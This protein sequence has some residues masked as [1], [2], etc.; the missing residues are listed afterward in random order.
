MDHIYTNK[1]TNVSLYEDT[2]TT[3]G[4]PYIITYEGKIVFT[5]DSWI[6][7]YQV[8]NNIIARLQGKRAK[9]A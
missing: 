9:I 5:T 7:A 3:N 4:T 1:E 2:Y 8:Y 6:Y